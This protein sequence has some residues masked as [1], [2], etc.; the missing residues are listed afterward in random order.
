[1]TFIRT[2]VSNTQYAVNFPYAQIRPRMSPVYCEEL[3]SEKVPS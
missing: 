3:G 1:M 2:H